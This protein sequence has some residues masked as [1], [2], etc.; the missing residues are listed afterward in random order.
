MKKFDELFFGTAGIPASTQRPDTVNGI[1]R[2]KELGLSA[3]EL[4]FVQNVNIKE[5]KAPLVRE[6]AEKNGVFLTCHGQYFIN[7]NSLDEKKLEASKERVYIAAKR[8][9][10]CGAWSMCFHPGFYQGKPA[11]ETFQTVKQALSEVLERLKSEGV[12]IWVRPET[13]GKPT[14]FGSLEEIV[15]LSL[16]LENVLPCI[17]FSHLYARS[18]GKYNSTEEFSFVLGF[19]E[20][21]LGKDALTRLHL[22][23]QGVE[24]SEKGEKRHLPFSESGFNYKDLVKVLRDFSAKGTVICESPLMEEDALILQKAYKKA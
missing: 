22:H 12:N 7:L 6:A 2:V 15:D 4:E 24:F 3:M 21:K 17:D 9:F 23:V 20:E 8:A 18:N 11:G 5:D 19:L 16:E 1:A 13:T 14:Q 10:Q